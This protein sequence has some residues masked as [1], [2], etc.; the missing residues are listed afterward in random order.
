[1]GTNGWITESTFLFYSNIPTSLEKWKQII[2][3]DLDGTIIKTKSGKKFPVNSQDWVYNYNNVVETIVGL[4]DTIIGIVS[5]QKGIKTNTQALEWENKLNS[6]FKN[7][8]FHFVFASLS[9]N[10]YRK[11]MTGSWQYVKENF[12]SGINVPTSKILYVGDACGRPD[13]FS[14]TDLKF[15][16]NCGFKFNTPEKFFN[17]QPTIKNKMTITYPELQ[18]Y[19]DKEFN[20]II[21]S[22]VNQALKNKTLIIIGGFPGCGKSFLRKLL[23]GQLP[24]CKY[25]NKDD[26]K[27]R[28]VNSNLVKSH[29]N[30]YDLIIDDNTNLSNSNRKELLATYKSH[31]KIGIYFDYS[32]ELAMHLNYARMFWYGGELIKKVAYYT[33]NKKYEEPNKND[34]DMSINL[35]KILPHFKIDSLLQYYF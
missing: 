15:A 14:D 30:S 4:P 18:Y 1:M 27:N 23:I 32:I 28:V 8:K 11:P 19:S 34:F 3:F 10:R 20:V 24:S 29:N 22:V 16:H 33:L 2:I 21:D 13:D 12:L 25:V 26:I 5:N 6:I 35:N 7:I 17:V 31:Y 9:D